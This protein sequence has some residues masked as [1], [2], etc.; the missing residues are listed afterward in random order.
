MTHVHLFEPSPT[1][2]KR[3]LLV[4]HGTGGDE[5]SLLQLA[6]SIEPNAALLSARGNVLEGSAPRFFRRLAEGVF[7]EPDLIARTHDLADFV[8]EAST[9]YGFD[10][11]QVIAVGY[12]NGANIAASLLLLRPESLCGA[13]LIRAMVPLEPM[14]LPNLI[15]KHV[16]M[17]TGEFDPILPPE[18]AQ[19]LATMLRKYGADVMYELLRAG[20]ELTRRDLDLATEWLSSTAC[21]NATS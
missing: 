2:S 1:N 18:N 4:L 19:R 20:H 3:T 15:G 8:A 11:N 12:S 5:R 14:T 7:D 16:L 10:P 17:L 21:P 6:R 9:N 13:A